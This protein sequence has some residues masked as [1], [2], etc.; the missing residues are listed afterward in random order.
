MICLGRISRTIIAMAVQVIIVYVSLLET[1]VNWTGVD[2]AIEHLLRWIW[3][4][5]HSPI[6]ASSHGSHFS[7]FATRFPSSEGQKG[8]RIWALSAVSTR[9]EFWIISLCSPDCQL[10]SNVAFASK[11]FFWD[12]LHIISRNWTNSSDSYKSKGSTSI[13]I[14]NLAR[15]NWPSCDT[16]DG[17][18]IRKTRKLDGRC[19]FTGECSDTTFYRTTDVWVANTRYWLLKWMLWRCWRESE[20][21]FLYSNVLPAMH[22]L[23]NL[24]T[25]TLLKEPK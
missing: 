16:S 8:G 12:G 25:L 18:G 9:E 21:A 19:F 22:R 3:A 11:V 13:L 4:S 17:I 23:L 10:Q 20:D 2:E 15:N 14:P 6:P 24:L 7:H 1:A 5:D